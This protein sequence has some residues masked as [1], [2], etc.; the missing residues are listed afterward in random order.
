MQP[1]ILL[2]VD[3][4]SQDG[5]LGEWE[6]EAIRHARSAAAGPEFHG[7]TLLGA[8]QANL[9][10]PLPIRLCN[11]AMTPT[12]T[13]ASRILVLLGET[14]GASDQVAEAARELEQGGWDVRVLGPAAGSQSASYRVGSAPM[15]L[16]VVSRLMGH[17]T[18]AYSGSCRHPLAYPDRTAAAQANAAAT[19]RKLTELAAAGRTGRAPRLLITRHAL[20]SV[21]DRLRSRQYRALTSTEN[22]TSAQL[23]KP[24]AQGPLSAIDLEVA[25]DAEIRTFRPDVIYAIGRPAALAAVHAADRRAAFG[26]RPAVVWQAKVAS[27]YDPSDGSRQDRRGARSAA[28]S[29]RRVDAVRGQSRESGLPEEPTLDS[30]LRTAVGSGPNQ[31]M[32]SATSKVLE[33][34]AQGESG[35]SQ[36][37]AEVSQWLM[38]RSDRLYGAGDPDLAL[39]VFARA[40]TIMFHRTL[41][42]DSVD[43]PLT[44]DPTNFLRPWHQSRLAAAAST[45]GCPDRVA[46]APEITASKR[47]ALISYKNFAFAPPVERAAAELGF[48]VQ[49]IDLADLPGSWPQSVSD[50]VELRTSGLDAA[51]TP[52]GKRLTELIGDADRVWVEWALAP[53]VAISMLPSP[54]RRTTVR[55]HAYE[56]WTAFPHLMDWS[57]ID[58]LVFVG[59]HIRDMIVPQLGGLDPHTTALTTMPVSVDGPKW[60][61]PK[62]AKARHTLAV[63]GWSA[64]A[65]DPIWAMDLLAQL[66][67]SDPR[68]RLLLVGQPPAEDGAVGIRNYGRKV[69]ARSSAEDV[70]DAIEFV[71]YT[72]EVPEL[73]RDV[74]VIISSSVNESLHLAV[75]E[76]AASGAVPVVRDWPMVAAFDGPRRIYPPEWVVTDLAEAASRILTATADPETFTEAGAQAAAVAAKRFDDAAVA[77]QMRKLLLG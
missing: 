59:P 47:L 7:G 34:L 18:S 24:G 37:L 40:A 67:N 62:T 55:L 51:R 28:R 14:G 58:D 75:I 70:R 50:L 72:S 33:L 63:I 10:R 71:P 1:R 32:V 60:L 65:K 17:R 30:V 21:L 4:G 77:K 68:F 6:S 56:A 42:F 43:S 11:S 76:G 16:V 5:D 39:P 54:H 57:A 13:Q 15:K 46:L 36:D 45:R 73:L 22:K 64:P 29:L 8:P 25:F 48:S 27:D 41:H 2:Y 35:D 31:A 38:E 61:K 44:A 69:L 23:S 74:G 26:P 20:H 49:R 12:S 52:W 9:H 19:Y 66:R 53:A 3:H